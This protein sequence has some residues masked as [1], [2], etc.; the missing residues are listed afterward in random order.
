MTIVSFLQTVLLLS[1]ESC[2][3]YRGLKGGRL[4]S[5]AIFCETHGEFDLVLGRTHALY[6]TVSR[7][8]T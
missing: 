1:L 3:M 4:E 5:Y 7:I 8:G 6:L 2:P